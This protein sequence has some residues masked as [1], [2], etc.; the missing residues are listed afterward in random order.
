MA[1][2]IDCTRAI[3]YARETVGIVVILFER[4]DNASSR[5][6]PNPPGSVSPAALRG[7][8]SAETQCK[9]ND[10]ASR[11]SHA[12]EVSIANLRA[13]G[14]ARRSNLTYGNAVAPLILT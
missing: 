14:G 4:K 13:L 11:S 3:E 2:R 12:G 8:K 1:G 10:G 6:P 9:K 7:K 5:L